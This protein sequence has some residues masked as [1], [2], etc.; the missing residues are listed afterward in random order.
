MAFLVASLSP[1]K[2]LT[3]EIELRTAP[4]LFDLAIALAAG[5][6]GAYAVAREDVSTSLPGVAI[7]AALVPPLGVV[8]YGLAVR[9]L[10]IAGGGWLLVFTNLIAIIL[11]GAVVLL[12][13]GFRPTRRRE[14]A[15]R[16]RMGLLLTSLMLLVIS[17]PL[18]V[19]FVDSIQQSTTMRRI[20]QSLQA[21]LEGN[22]GIEIIEVDF[23]QQEDQLL[24]MLTIESGVAQDG[25]LGDQL[26]Q[27]LTDELGAEVHLELTTILVERTEYPPPP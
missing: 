17:I 15:A 24:V 1:L 8:G 18:A 26:L 10:Q 19:V 3:F 27:A 13:L 21:S 25:S 2:V 20:E 4:N 5:A 7:A 14:R 6:A 16:L 11:S 22:E 9:D 23:S 12:L